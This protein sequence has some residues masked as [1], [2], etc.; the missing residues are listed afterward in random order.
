MSTALHR[1]SSVVWLP[2]S[3]DKVISSVDQRMHDLHAFVATG[4]REERGL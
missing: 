4:C 3:G 1:Q 2:C